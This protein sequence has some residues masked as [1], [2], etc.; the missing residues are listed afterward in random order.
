MILRGKCLKENKLYLRI[1]TYCLNRITF[2][3]CLQVSK[4]SLLLLSEF[5]ISLQE[6]TTEINMKHRNIATQS[7]TKKAMLQPQTSVYSPEIRYNSLFEE[8]V[9]K[10]L[11]AFCHMWGRKKKR[12][13]PIHYKVIN[14]YLKCAESIVIQKFSKISSFGDG[15]AENVRLLLLF[16][17]AGKN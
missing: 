7:T 9:R 1:D 17:S 5:S 12:A 4:S 2:T 10:A 16:E 13:V 11:G 3:T 15:L 6:T 8:L 14:C